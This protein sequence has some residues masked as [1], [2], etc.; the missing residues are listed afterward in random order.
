MFHSESPDFVKNRCLKSLTCNDSILPRIVI[1]TSAIGCGINVKGLKHVCHFGPAYSLV[2][3]CQQIGRAG[4]NNESGCHAV[5]YTYPSPGNKINQQMKAYT[6]LID[7]C[8][9][10]KLFSPF[11]DSKHVP[12]LEIGHDC[13]SICTL[14]CTCGIDHDSLFL[15]EKESEFFKPL[16]KVPI[17]EV[18]LSD[19][20][21]IRISLNEYH[22]KCLSDN[23]NLPSS[24]MSGLT[25]SIVSTILDELEF[26]DSPK[27]L[28][29]NLCI[30]DLNIAQSVY[31]IVSD[32]YS[33]KD[34][35][36]LFDIDMEIEQSEKTPDPSS[37][38][39]AETG[40]NEKYTFS[41]YEDMSDI[42]V[43][44]ESF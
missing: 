20:E 8:L 11:N 29:D 23:L 41:D 13:C 33:N 42:D 26:I 34:L 9:R 25:Q 14:S 1:A 35:N 24:S 6:K 22:R 27:F 15:F 21:S 36:D 12:P 37:V 30:L 5:L 18:S 19:R 4:R 39:V 2:D 7:A 3:Y 10:T 43:D 38:V 40:N 28:M 16:P 31:E 44:L 32:F 17:R